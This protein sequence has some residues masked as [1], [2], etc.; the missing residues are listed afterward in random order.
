MLVK[1]ERVVD[2]H[3]FHSISNAT[4]AYKTVVFLGSV[5]VIVRRASTDGVAP[6]ATTEFV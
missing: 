6:M 4:L 3:R 1:R 2:S 5:E